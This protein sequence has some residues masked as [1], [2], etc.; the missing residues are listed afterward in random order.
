[1][2]I[3]DL[4][5]YP[6]ADGMVLGKREYD[7]YQYLI[8]RGIFTLWNKR[9]MIWKKDGKYQLLRNVAP[10]PELEAEASTLDG[11]V[12]LFDIPLYQFQWHPHWIE[13]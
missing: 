7:E 4:P 3:W 6:I 8:D 12:K 1:M 2:K 10:I 13:D 5:T 9:H 11:L